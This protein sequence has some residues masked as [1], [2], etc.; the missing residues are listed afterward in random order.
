MYSVL[1]LEREVISYKFDSALF[2]IFQAFVAL[3]WVRPV[4]PVCPEIVSRGP[5]VGTIMKLPVI[6]GSSDPCIGSSD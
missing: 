3:L 6:I 2:L 1:V 5:L 4:R